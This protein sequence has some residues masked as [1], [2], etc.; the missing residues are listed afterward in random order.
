[1]GFVP[2]RDPVITIIVMIDS[3]SA[4]PDTGGVVAAPI[5][6]RIAEQALRYLGVA[7]T[8]NARPPVLV[9]RHGETPIVQASATLTQPVI[10][11]LPATSIQPTVPDLRG[12]SARE[13]MRS[14]AELGLTPR[15]RGSGIVV[16]QDPLPG[17]PLERGS[18]CMLILDRAPQPTAGGIQP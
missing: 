12:L 17:M 13:A 3:P 7:P 11:P 15:L 2:S 1:V 4:G 16:D 18:V 14:L 9:A 5:F 6:Q 10:V 8:V